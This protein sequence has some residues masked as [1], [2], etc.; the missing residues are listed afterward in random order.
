[1]K[2]RVLRAV[3]DHLGEYLLRTPS[4]SDCL[5]DAL[6]A[7]TPPEA[8]IVHNCRED[9][10]SDGDEE[11]VHNYCYGTLSEA[12]SLAEFRDRLQALFWVLEKKDCP[13]LREFSEA[14][15]LAMRNSPACDLRLTRAGMKVMIVPS[16]ARLLDDGVIN[17]VLDWLSKY[18][19]VQASFAKALSIFFERKKELRRNSLDE[20]RFALEQLLRLVLHNHRQLEK[21]RDDLAKWLNQEGVNQGVINLLVELLSKFTQYQNE[22]VKHGDRSAWAEV[23]FMI[24]LTGTFMRFLLEVGRTSRQKQPEEVAL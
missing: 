20:L 4:V 12:K 2:S 1:M 23:E 16:G 19:S 14:V 11:L 10:F 13:K 8:R 24:Y 17:D 18:P 9:P 22:S 7:A 15:G 3:D 21:Q 6:G 5:A